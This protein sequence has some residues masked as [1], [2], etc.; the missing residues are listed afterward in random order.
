MNTE[1]DEMSRKGLVFDIK[2]MALFDGPGIRTTV[3]LKGCPLKCQWC[4]NPEGISPEPQLMV[5][6]SGCIECGLC[7]TVC[8]PKERCTACGACVNVCPAGIRR[9]AGRYYDSDGLAA[10]LL[11]D[12]LFLEKQQGGVTFSGGEPLLQAAFVFEVID[13]LQ[14]MHTAIETSGYCSEAV[15]TQMLEKVDYILMDIK[16][17]N[18]DEH[19]KYTG[20]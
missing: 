3:F 8:N 7:K 10:E 14:G 9:V 17:I 1:K 2:Q 18:E 15:F 5:A 16:M 12:K 13:K 19:K 4:H 20:V 11:K 6:G